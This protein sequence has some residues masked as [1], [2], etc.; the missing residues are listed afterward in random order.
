DGR[1][2][3]NDATMLQK[4]LAEIRV[5]EGTVVINYFYDDEGVQKKLTDTIT[6]NGRVGDP[7][8]SEQYY[9]MGYTLDESRLPAVTE[10][11]IPY[12]AT[13]T[14]N[15]YYIA[16]SPEV[17]L[18]FKHSGS[19]TWNPTLWIWGSGLDGKD[20][21]FNATGGT[22]PG[23][24]AALNE[25]T[26]WYDYDFTY[27]GAGTYNVIVSNAGKNQTA[28][29]KGFGY[30]EMWVIID[31]SKIDG[32]NYVTFYDANPETTPGARVIPFHN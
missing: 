13:L 31:D 29:C 32:G 18:H 9:V 23:R 19:L 16:G 28:D 15:Y 11:K 17:S 10:G 2:T 30:N 3:I 14:I 6:I 1:T 27:Q 20:T 12:G 4:Y 22:W 5:S 21:S 8:T 26:G 7:F 24:P 25:S